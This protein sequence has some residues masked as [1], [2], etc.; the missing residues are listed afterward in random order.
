MS[1][2]EWHSGKVSW[3]NK[4]LLHNEIL[5]NELIIV[6][7]WQ[8]WYQLTDVS[9]RLFLSEWS[10][11]CYSRSNMLH[12]FTS[13]CF[14]EWSPVRLCQL[15]SDNSNHFIKTGC[16]IRL[17]ILRKRAVNNLPGLLPRSSNITDSCLLTSS[18][19]K[20]LNIHIQSWESDVCQCS[21]WIPLRLIL[22]QSCEL[23]ASLLVWQGFTGSRVC[24]CVCLPS[25]KL[26]VCG[27][28]VSPSES[29]MWFGGC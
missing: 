22:Q 6:S 18:L 12:V 7:P 25:V 1:C 27:F 11:F 29:H 24:V 9:C 20:L 2:G 15:N 19:V 28:M 4:H 21:L 3:G 8:T 10:F 17:I 23:E 5:L 26:T 13:R 16:L 14:S